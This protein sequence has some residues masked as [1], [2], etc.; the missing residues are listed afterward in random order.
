MCQSLELVHSDGLHNLLTQLH[1][2]GLLARLVVDE[3]H[4]VSQWGHDFRPDYVTVGNVRNKYPGIPL[5]AL[6]AT[7]TDKVHRDVMNCLSMQNVQKFSRSFN[8]PELRYEVR[9]KGSKV[10][11]IESIAEY[12]LKKYKDESGIIYCTSRKDCE[13]T[14]DLLLEKF[15]GTSLEGKVTYYHAGNERSVIFIKIN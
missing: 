3:A 7:V 13:E 5:T 6:T 12:I 4:C 1:S 2:K 15:R 10:K 8:R 9:Q 14:C 11:T